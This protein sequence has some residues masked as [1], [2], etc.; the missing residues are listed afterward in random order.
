[1]KLQCFFN[2][3]VCYVNTFGVASNAWGQALA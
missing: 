2:L 3:V 1:V